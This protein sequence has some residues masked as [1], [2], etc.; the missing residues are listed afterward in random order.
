MLGGGAQCW[1]GS[2]A[3][4]KSVQTG[5]FLVFLLAIVWIAP[6]GA[7]SLPGDMDE[8]LAAALEKHSDAQRSVAITFTNKGYLDFAANW[9]YYVREHG[10]SNYLIF[11]LDSEAYDTLAAMEANVFLADVHAQQGGVDRSATEFGSDPFKKIVHLK[12]TL[13]LRVLELGFSLLLSDAD[14]VWLQ[15]P[16]NVPAVTGSPLNLMSDAHF[17]LGMGT[18]PYFV[19]S[20][21]AYMTPEAST[22]SFMREV[23]RLLASRPDKMD[24]DAYNTA[25]SNWKRRTD[26]PLTLS[27]MDPASISNGWVFFMR[28]L[29]QRENADMVAVHNNWADGLDGNSYHQKA[30]LPRPLHPVPARPAC[31]RSVRTPRVGARG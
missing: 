11:A 6:A 2:R 24:Q 20:G 8:R 25:I 7:V 30:R 15:N 1:S 16:F 23:V 21:F 31:A 17:G 13:T 12:P 5:L 18:T 26:E 9:L 4:H 28:R 22:L 14:V 19:N 27:I 10:V 29:G 3:Q